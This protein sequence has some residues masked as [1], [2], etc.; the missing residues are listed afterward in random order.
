MNVDDRAAILE[1]YARYAH[2]IDSGDAAGCA[3]CFTEQGRM[4]V[5]AARPVEGREALERFAARWRRDVAG[6][7]RH[8]S[9]HVI[10]TPVDPGSVRG[11][12]SSAL[13]ETTASGVSLAFTGRYEDTFTREPDGTW[14]IAERLV[15]P[16][17][18]LLRS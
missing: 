10:L 7:P 8:A 11:V 15:I 1:L 17:A 2:S 14:L 3:R 5:G 18:S 9:W 16:D 13:I 12:A 4:R 6:I